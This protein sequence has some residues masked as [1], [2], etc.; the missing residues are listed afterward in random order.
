MGGSHETGMPGLV[1]KVI[2]SQ[3]ADQEGT[4]SVYCCHLSRWICHL[5]VFWLVY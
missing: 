4:D 2:P 3:D 5:P 1:G